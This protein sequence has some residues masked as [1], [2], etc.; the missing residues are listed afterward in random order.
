MDSVPS[1][2]SVTLSL[3]D[4]MDEGRE[5]SAQSVPQIF[6]L[7]PEIMQQ[8]FSYL[9]AEHLASLHRTCR[10]LQIHATEDKLWIDLLKTR[11]PIH[12]FPDTPSPFSSFRELYL[13][14]HP[15][16]FLP[17]H[18]IWFSDDAYT[19]KLILIKFNPKRGSIEGYRVAAERPPATPEVWSYKPD[20]LIHHLN[21]HV[22][23]STNDPVLALSPP[24]TTSSSSTSSTSWTPTTEIPMRIG[25]PTQ[26]IDA[27]LLLSI[28]L[29]EPTASVPAVS[30]WPP[31]IIPDMPRTRSSLSSGAADRF[32]SR[33]HKPQT[34]SE[35]SQ[36][37]FRTRTWSHFTQ[38]I[39][40]LGPRIG[41]AVSTWSTL[42][43]SLYTP[44]AEKPYQG[45]FVGDYAAH[46]CEILLVL[47]SDTAPISARRERVRDDA[48]NR[49][50]RYLSAILAA[51]N[52]E[53]L[54]GGEDPDFDPDTPELST[55]S[56]LDTKEYQNATFS[57]TPVRPNVADPDGNIH[58]GA[59]QAIKLTGDVNIPRGE[60]T[61]VADD[62]GP[63][64]TIRIA[65][66]KPFRGARVVKSRGHV[67]GRGF[68]EGRFD[69]FVSL[70]RVLVLLDRFL[71][72]LGFGIW[73]KLL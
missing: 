18:K 57:Q 24:I 68:M 61:F 38:G 40:N 26:K 9:S 28:D 22:Y 4:D 3:D 16:W 37:T 17:H 65:A 72:D 25:A 73:C 29:P 64:G 27:S 54:A 23:V 15:Y 43:P 51:L 60:H 13:S 39:L 32:S 6:K 12:D 19:G 1:R 44:T 8:I 56:Y 5:R 55:S 69:C 35:I 67:A 58:K 70:S 71:C 14:H 42:C 21:P 20:V 53:S 63:A 2:L 46:G 50:S 30:V 7:P 59:I 47:Q 31:R 41:E 52:D 62:I 10:G 49:P 36:T 34:L 33:K 66:E 48:R 11:I 45:I